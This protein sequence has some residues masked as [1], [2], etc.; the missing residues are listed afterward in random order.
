MVSVIRQ[1]TSLA[2]VLALGAVGACT[3]AS[4][5]FPVSPEE[6]A[7]IEQDVTV[8]RLDA[9][10]VGSFGAFKQFAKAT[11]LPSHTPGNIASVQVTSFPFSS[12][13]IRNSPSR[14]GMTKSP[15]VFRSRPTAR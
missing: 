10:N 1:K 14:Q 4:V 5:R 8:V 3:D 6:Q 15:R 2:L 13:T 7:K 11:D 12:L 9:G